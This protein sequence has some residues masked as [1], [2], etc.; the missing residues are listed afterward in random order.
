[1][2]RPL[3]PGDV[4]DGRYRIE[5]VLGAGGMGSLFIATQLGFERE[6]ALKVLRPKP[7]QDP[8]AQTRFLLEAKAVCS[9]Q[10]PNIVTYHDFGTDP[11]TGAL[12][13]VMELLAG[14]SL[15]EVLKEQAPLPVTRVT[16]IMMQLCGALAEAH[17]A[18]VIHRDLKP[19]N[20]M[21]VRRGAD[22][23]FVKLIDFGIVRVMEQGARRG[24]KM[25]TD[26]GMVIGTTGYLAPEYIRRQIVDERTDIYAVGIMLYELI[27]GRRPFVHE[28]PVE[29]LRMHMKQAPVPITELQHLG[30]SAV[31]MRAINEIVLKA[32]EKDPTQRTRSIGALKAHLEFATRDLRA[33]EHADETTL[34][35]G[36]DADDDEQTTSYQP[37][38]DTA[39]GRGR[40]TKQVSQHTGALPRPGPKLSHSDSTL[41]RPP[42]TQTELVPAVDRRLLYAGFGTLALVAIMSA[43][44]LW[45]VLTRDQTAPPPQKAAATLSSNGERAETPRPKPEP[46]PKAAPVEVVEEAPPAT[47]EVAKPATVEAAPEV[48]APAV[49]ERPDKPVAE[50]EVAVDRQPVA[51]VAP[52]KN[53]PVAVV[54]AKK[55]RDRGTAT[56]KVTSVPIATI[57]L[58]KKKLGNLSSTQTIPA[59]KTVCFTAKKPLFTTTKQCLKLK[60]GQHQNLVLKLKRE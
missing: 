12:Y 56:V 46:P 30:R 34:Q 20:I 21:I 24:D 26:M 25:I 27:A 51:A 49:V 57:Y 29:V 39:P 36:L 32:L 59:N 6:V 1:M 4:V 58:G 52:P 31:D 28:K 7:K 45:F 15:A 53:E 14:A 33:A 22:P 23:D 17:A 50:V 55:P 11:D 13:L 47:V 3:Q 9:I 48:A 41:P 37:E 8:E 54:E 18:G 35:A 38:V 16:H 10:H 43:T 2:S 19:A 60:K 40:R 44:A 42:V 5:R